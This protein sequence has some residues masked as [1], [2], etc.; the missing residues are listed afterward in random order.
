MFPTAVLGCFTAPLAVTLLVNAVSPSRCLVA[1][2]IVLYFL[3]FPNVAPFHLVPAK[4][5]LAGLPLIILPFSNEVYSEPLY[6]HSAEDGEGFEGLPLILI[7]LL[8]GVVYLAA[9]D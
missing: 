7:R 8:M 6:A 2:E 9:T 3:V 4:A 1:E 5:H